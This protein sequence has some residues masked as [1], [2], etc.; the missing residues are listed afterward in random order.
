MIRLK[1]ILSV[2]ASLMA[3]A[4]VSVV[5]A[6]I[7]AMIGTWKGTTHAI[8]AGNGGNFPESAGTFEKPFLA[9]KAVSYEITGQQ[10]Q[11]FWGKVT[12]TSKDGAKTEEPF[13]GHLTGPDNHT[14][15]MADTDGYYNG[16][17]V[18]N[19]QLSYVSA[20]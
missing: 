12:F 1:T 7:P 11:R 5:A 3:T 4:S 6:E 2:A 15:L 8:I 10:D 9:E 18:G 16:K 19:N 13:I 14:V 17:L 20:S